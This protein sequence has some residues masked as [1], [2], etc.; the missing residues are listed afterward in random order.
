[1]E[2]PTLRFLGLV[3]EI[4]LDLCGDSDPNLTG[5][6]RLRPE[7]GS[8]LDLD[9]CGVVGQLALM[10]S[11]DSLD[12]FRLSLTLCIFSSGDSSLLIAFTL[13]GVLP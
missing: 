12:N 7:G 1:M 4:E 13:N 5:W 10:F 2:T 9:A 3:G 6:D 11:R 8:G